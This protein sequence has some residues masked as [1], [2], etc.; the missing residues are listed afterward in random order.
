MASN[1][2]VEQNGAGAV[3]A[4]TARVASDGLARHPHVQ[5]LMESSGADAARDLADAV[6]MLCALHGSFPGFADTALTHCSDD[7][8]RD[9]LREAADGFERERG[10][11]VALT[12]AA[13]P[14]PSTPGSAQ[15]ETAIQAQRHAIETLAS[16]ERRGC[17]LGAATALA[18][19]WP[20][21]RK[22]LDKAAT[23]FSVDAPDMVLPSVEATEAAI[24]ATADTPGPERA[25]GFG[26]EQMLLQHRAL[27]DLLEA[28]ADARD[29]D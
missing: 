11:L 22:I 29:D 25:L 24:A 16:S 26:S 17:S 5:S 2:V 21:I 15:S 14:L 27:F 23:R 12:S 28:R 19:D 9:W 1:P 6:H 10:L 8:S 13:G 20:V 3:A 7:A 18:L 4:Q